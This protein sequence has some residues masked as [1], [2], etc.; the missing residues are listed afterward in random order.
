MLLLAPQALVDAPLLVSELA[1]ELVATLEPLR[2]ELARFDRAEHGAARLAFVLAVAKLATLR[3]RFDVR[4]R[5]R[6]ALAVVVGEE[7]ELAQARRVD[8]QARAG[9][10]CQLAAGRGVPA[11][12]VVLAQLAGAPRFAPEQAIAQ[13][14]LAGTRRA[15]QHRRRSG[16]HAFSQLLDAGKGPRAHR[17]K[18]HS[19]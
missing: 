4:K 18:L 8:E 11:A 19:R 13:A 2:G 7:R 15:E 17:Q 14:R 3:Q 12:R 6:R 9:Q 5:A 10:A 1:L 16:R